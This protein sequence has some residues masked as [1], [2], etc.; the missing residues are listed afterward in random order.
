MLLKNKEKRKNLNF[1]LDLRTVVVY[2][3]YIAVVKSHDHNIRSKKIVRKKK[4]N[5]ILLYFTCYFINI[6]ALYK[7][8]FI[9]ISRGGELSLLKCPGN[10]KGIHV[11]LFF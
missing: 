4:L 8:I 5:N 1:K 3:D 6:L 11:P 9:L 7:I 2:S 10:Y